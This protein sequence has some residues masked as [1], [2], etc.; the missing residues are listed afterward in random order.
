[1]KIIP[2]LITAVLGFSAAAQTSD[3]QKKAKKPVTTKTP[4]S[5]KIPANAVPVGDGTFR[6]TDKNGKNWI[7]SNTPFGV[8]KTE[9]RQIVKPV[10]NPATD[11][12]TTR[13]QGDS[14]EFTR[15]TPFGNK[16]W[17]K[18]KADLDAYEKSLV[19]RDQQ[20]QNKTSSADSRGT[21]DSSAAAK[22]D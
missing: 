8:S 12:T 14:V 21:T 15:P 16:V 1:M 20:K 10:A 4:E 13:D 3:T 17:T 11:L 2:I 7:Y 9:E 18:K 5:P 19:E 22:Q 6:Y